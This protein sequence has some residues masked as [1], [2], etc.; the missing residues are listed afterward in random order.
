MSRILAFAGSKQA[1][2][3]TCCNF[4]HGYQLRSHHIVKDFSISDEGDLVVDTV[5]VEADGTEST[6]QGVLDVTRTDA[7]FAPWAAYNMWPFIKHYSFAAP[8]KELSIGLFTLSED[9]CFGSN[10]QKNSLT[11][12]RWEDMPGVTTNNDDSGDYYHEPGR[13]TAR[14]FLQYFGT[15]ICRKIHS[16]IWTD[17]TFRKIESEESLLALISDCRFPNEAEA[18]KKAGG[19]LIHLTRKPFEDTH[20]SETSL[21][22]YESYDAVIDNANL[23]INETNTEIVR[24]LD[25]WGWLGS[26]I[27]EPEPETESEPEGQEA[28][29]IM[30]IKPE[31]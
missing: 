9:Q 25:E 6:S 30:Q 19:K 31:E 27:E 7:E 1:G 13:M 17:H 20:E 11:W 28:G 12:L 10:A 2:K 8:L 26:V 22:G 29:G 23:S 24:L 18:V 4:L 3:N 16:D 15:N 21:D 14:E 5:F